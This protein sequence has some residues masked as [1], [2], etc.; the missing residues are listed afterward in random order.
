MSVS[1]M[2]NLLKELNK[3]ILYKTPVSKIL[4]YYTSS[5]NSVTDLYEYNIVFMTDP[6]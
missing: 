3:I 4:F 2:L 1:S 5:I 6:K